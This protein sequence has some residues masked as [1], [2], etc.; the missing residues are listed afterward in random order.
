MIPPLIW[1][2]RR[3]A[4]NNASRTSTGMVCSGPLGERQ[5]QAGG[6]GQRQCARYGRR[7]LEAPPSERRVFKHVRG[8]ER[9]P[10]RRRVSAHPPATTPTEKI[11]LWVLR[12]RKRLGG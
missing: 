7:S 1:V 10:F 8:F 3:L 11:A 4:P 5:G 12:E 6:Y 9:F 2:S